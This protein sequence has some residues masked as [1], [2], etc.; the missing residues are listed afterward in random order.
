MYLQA[1]MVLLVVMLMLYGLGGKAGYNLNTQK[2][3]ED[4]K[5]NVCAL[6]VVPSFLS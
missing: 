2:P 4:V 3:L 6:A 1:W 5:S